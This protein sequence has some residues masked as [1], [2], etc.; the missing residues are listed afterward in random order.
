MYQSHVA[1]Y[2]QL[3]ASLEG[4]IGVGKSTLLERL[5]DTQALVHALRSHIKG[6]EPV[7]LLLLEPS[8][9][10]EEDGTLADFNRRLKADSRHLVADEEKKQTIKQL[11]DELREMGAFFFQVNAFTS[12]IDFIRAAVEETPQYDLLLVERSVLADRY[13]FW[14]NQEVSE[15]TRRIYEN[16]WDKWY[17]FIPKIN[18]VFLLQTSMAEI[19]RRIIKRS[20]R[21]EGII[22]TWYLEK[23]ETSHQRYFGKDSE[24]KL[25]DIHVNTI[26]VT[27][28]HTTDHEAFVTIVRAMI[29]TML[30][31]KK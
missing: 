19:Q 10:W 20:R 17:H 29:D 31:L 4:C 12:R 14:E 30:A 9:A 21:A 8:E 24:D 23:L 22:P 18:C 7:V 11:D 16:I 27:K 1:S 26:D 3:C 25:A 5:R 2:W 6:R 28:D 13:V 15:T